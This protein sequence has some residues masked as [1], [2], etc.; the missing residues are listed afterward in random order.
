MVCVTSSEEQ[1]GEQVGKGSKQVVEE[2]LQRGRRGVSFGWIW[3]NSP[4]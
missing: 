2:Q 4:E 1:E 3:V